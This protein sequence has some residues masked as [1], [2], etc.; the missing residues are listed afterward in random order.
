[1]IKYILVF[2]LLSLLIQPLHA[3]ELT[4]R[5]TQ[6]DRLFD[7]A[8]YFKSIDLYLKLAEIDKPQPSR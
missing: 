7:R 2:L 8:E 6:A 5:R 4:S 3:Q 1:M